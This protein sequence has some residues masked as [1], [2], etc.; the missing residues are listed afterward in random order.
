MRLVLDVTS[1]KHPL[2]GQSSHFVFDR[3]GGGIGRAQGN[4]CVLPDPERYI[5]SQHAVIRYQ[6]GEY[7]LTDTSVNGVYLN[8]SEQPVGR[9]N[10]VRLQDG[11]CL[12][13]G[14]YEL[15]VS[16]EPGN[17]R[18]NLNL[19]E[20]G[21]GSDAAGHVIPPWGVAD[22]EAP[23]AAVLDGSRQPAE[24]PGDQNRGRGDRHA[25]RPQQATEPDHTPAE[26]QHFSPPAYKME[27]GAEDWDR[28]DLNAPSQPHEDALP[29]WDRTDLGSPTDAGTAQPGQTSADVPDW[30]RT[31]VTSIPAAAPPQQQPLNREADATAGNGNSPAPAIQHAAEANHQRDVTD[32]GRQIEPPPP[33]QVGLPSREVPPSGPAVSQ[34]E[35]LQAFFE[36]AGLDASKITPDAVPDFMRLFGGLYR[37]IVQGLMEVL[38][39]RS[40][41]KNEFR[42]RHTQISPRENNPLK[43]SGRVE[44]ALEHLVFN[45]GAGFLPPEAA[46]QEAFHDI[47][48]HQIAMV[49][50]MRAAFESLLRRFDPGLLEERVTRGNKIGNLVPVNRKAGCWD[51]Y[52]EWYEEIIAAA[53]DNFQGLFGDEFTRAYE[54]Q[55]ARLALLRK[56]SG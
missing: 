47:K 41:L 45:S 8:H 26:Q 13:M 1:S 18:E 12:T 27:G 44:D 31:S 42:M 19:P 17:H 56:R 55:V 22:A 10:S 21:A 29:D 38:R 7:L 32:A 2:P 28:T 3:H 37:E 53:E 34:Q 43:F 46:F 16:I 52:V 50:G 20:A 35:A 40:D 39:A 14:D 6:E 9:N 54:E 5:S 4:D 49:V 25:S 33:E 23:P 11:D 30:D 24:I 51:R 15:R 48:D 36:A